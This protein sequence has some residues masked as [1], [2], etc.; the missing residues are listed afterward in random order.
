MEQ[1]EY[2]LCEVIALI[3]LEFH[4]LN[5]GGSRMSSA[6]RVQHQRIRLDFD[7]I[8]E[9]V[10]S[11]RGGKA[12]FRYNHQPKRK[13]RR[14]D[15]RKRFV[16]VMKVRKRSPT[17]STITRYSFALAKCP[18]TSDLKCYYDSFCTGIGDVCHDEQLCLNSDHLTAIRN[19]L[20]GSQQL[21]WGNRLKKAK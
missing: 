13:Y 4:L 20:L 1:Y 3:I 19:T 14:R 6:W 18:T 7:S 8:Y 21:V 10:K 16:L 11:S 17:L 9:A 5:E 2:Q 12:E 15:Q